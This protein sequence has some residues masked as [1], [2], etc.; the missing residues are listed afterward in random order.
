MSTTTRIGLA[1]LAELKLIRRWLAAIF[2]LL[3]QRQSPPAR[4]PTAGFLEI[5]GEQREA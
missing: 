2:K 4:I 3:L 5:E 1:Q